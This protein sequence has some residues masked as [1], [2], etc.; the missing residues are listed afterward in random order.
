MRAHFIFVILEICSSYGNISIE[1]EAR[2][3]VRDKSRKK[4]RLA[5]AAVDFAR[6]P[7]LGGDGVHHGAVSP[8]GLP[9]RLPADSVIVVVR[10]A[11]LLEPGER[12]LALQMCDKN[13]I[14]NLQM[15]AVVPLFI[16]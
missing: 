3:P 9:G 6:L 4:D 11:A 10:R 13:Y 12:S 5:E 1:S 15:P 8:A 2:S 16:F 7:P 14:W